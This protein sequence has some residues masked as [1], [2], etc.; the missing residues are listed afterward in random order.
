MGVLS[1]AE[2][3]DDGYHSAV[4]LL[5]DHDVLQLEVAVHD[6]PLVQVRHTL[7]QV[8]HDG[9][10]LLQRG[11]TAFLDVPVERERVQLQYD[12][13]GVVTLVDRHQLAEI[14]VV[15]QGQHLELA[16]KRGLRRERRTF[17]LP[18]SCAK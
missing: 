9:L 14:S 12:V 18:L 2:V 8:H 13:R 1:E 6:A 3:H 4:A 7:E 16:Q 17:P 5:L 11:E 10:R 15:H